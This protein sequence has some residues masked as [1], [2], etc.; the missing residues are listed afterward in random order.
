MRG[1][2]QHGFGPMLLCLPATFMELVDA[3]AKMSR[4][5]PDL[6]QCHQAIAGSIRIDSAGDLI[7]SRRE[8]ISVTK[9]K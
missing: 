6:V 7:D 1:T 3:Q 9:V 2:G 5:A 4:I 8:I